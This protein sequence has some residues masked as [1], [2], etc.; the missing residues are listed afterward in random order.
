M[1]HPI[2]L[3]AD[4]VASSFAINGFNDAMD[5]LLLENS[6]NIRK[7]WLNYFHN[8]NI[9]WLPNQK[10]YKFTQGIQLSV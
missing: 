7:I 1:H 5:Q 6:S 4:P 9:D 2:R 8:T 3:S 10:I